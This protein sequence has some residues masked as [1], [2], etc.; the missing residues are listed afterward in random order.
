MRAASSRF[1]HLL[2]GV[3]GLVVPLEGGELL[4]RV[5]KLTGSAPLPEEQKARQ[6]HPRDRDEA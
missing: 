2:L 6:N 1:S 5:G 4:L 3:E